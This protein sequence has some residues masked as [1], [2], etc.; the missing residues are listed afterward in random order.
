MLVHRSW[1]VGGALGGWLPTPAS[2]QSVGN[3]MSGAV[4][5]TVRYAAPIPAQATDFPPL[6][7]ASG[8]AVVLL[9]DLL[10]CTLRRVPLAGL[11]LLAAF[12]VPVSVL[13]G[14]SWL[15]FALAA[16]SFV[17]LLAADQAARLGTWGRSL[18][19]SVTDSQPHSVGL[20]TVWPTATRIGFAGIGL[21]V[22]AP[23]VL[24]VGV[25]TV[26]GR[27]RHRDRRGR[28]GD[29]LEPDA[30]RPPRPDAR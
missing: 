9:V 6:M 15:A 14:V 5:A 30:R 22:L 13:G 23:A 10:A 24:P 27:R 16:A 4:D 2:L 25:G 26:H 12:T 11:P 21:A 8:A 29:H 7:L 1:A 17:F 19:G 28:R 20:G 3:L 18:A